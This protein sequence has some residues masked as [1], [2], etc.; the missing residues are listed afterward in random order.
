MFARILLHSILSSFA[1]HVCVLY[2]FPF[3]LWLLIFKMCICTS[4]RNRSCHVWI[5]HVTFESVKSDINQ[6]SHKWVNLHVNESYHTWMVPKSGPAPSRVQETL[7]HS[8][9][10]QRLVLRAETGHKFIMSLLWIWGL[11]GC[12][13]DRSCGWN[14]GYATCRA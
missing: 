12:L 11:F 13:S 3:V 14:L 6:P 1:F 9:R 7:L 10:F 2:P 4:H 8:T 5:N